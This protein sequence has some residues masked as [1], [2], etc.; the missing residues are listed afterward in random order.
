LSGWESG[1]WERRWE[2]RGRAVK[3]G[4]DGEEEDREWDLEGE[5]EDFEEVLEEDE[6]DFCF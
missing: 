3:A 4:R 5:E 1:S 6:E 2:L